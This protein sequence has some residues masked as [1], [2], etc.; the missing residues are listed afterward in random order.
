MREPP[1]GVRLHRVERCW[2]RTLFIVVIVGPVL[3]TA[4]VGAT[5]LGLALFLVIFIA[6]GTILIAREL[7]SAVSLLP[8]ADRVER[9]PRGLHFRL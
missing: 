6:A 1:A 7:R 4:G 3:A 8:S 9:V 5:L 2:L